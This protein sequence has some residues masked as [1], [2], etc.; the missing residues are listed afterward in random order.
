MALT[1]CDRFVDSGWITKDS[2]FAFIQ[3]FIRLTGAGVDGKVVALMVDN[4][5]SRFS[6]EMWIYAAE[7]GVLLFALPSNSTGKMQP[8]DV[9]PGKE[10][11]AALNRIHD[12]ESVN[13]KA[14]PL[15]RD[16]IVGR[17]LHRAWDA[18]F[19]RRAILVGWK[20][21][22]FFP[23]NR[24][25]VKLEE[26]VPQPEAAVAATETL[27]VPADLQQILVLPSK[28]DIAA[29]HAALAKKRRGRKPKLKPRCRVLTAVGE[30]KMAAEIRE[31]ARQKAIGQEKA[32]EEKEKKKRERE[33]KKKAKDA[34][35]EEKKRRR[36]EK[37][38]DNEAKR[39]EKEEKKRKRA[40]KKK[41]TE[42]KKMRLAAGRG[43]KKKE[44]EAKR[45][46]KENPEAAVAAESD[47]RQRRADRSR[48]WHTVDCDSDNEHEARKG[49][50]KGNADSSE[51]EMDSGS[52]SEWSGG[53]YRE[54][55]SDSDDEG[56]AE[57]EP[58]RDGNKYSKMGI[59]DAEN[60]DSTPPKRGRKRAA[61]TS[62][63]QPA[64]RGRNNGYRKLVYDDLK[65][66]LRFTMF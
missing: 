18:G 16:N 64:K 10:F 30:Q 54:E 65:K 53:E 17:V 19:T 27:P 20:N 15:G 49:Q 47:S 11:R 55:N 61:E 31:K 23:L 7:N 28:D 66:G 59:V 4:H 34:D 41:K 46:E 43:R 5:T 62:S 26:L 58:G 21:S 1:L 38:R 12:D 40:E 2:F 39:N 35:K 25:A 29:F 9:G 50:R 63:E 42:E 57:T 37:K 51:N 14:D 32:A 22:G 6:E 60:K 33:E 52:E 24:H 48:R 3:Y 8:V 44:R 45:E 36:E 13:F 56:G